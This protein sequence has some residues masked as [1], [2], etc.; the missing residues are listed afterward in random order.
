[1]A[2]LGKKGKMYVARF[3]Y[4]GKEYKRSLKTTTR[5]TPKLHCMLWNVRSMA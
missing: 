2:N 3:R 1:M 4:E 5:Q